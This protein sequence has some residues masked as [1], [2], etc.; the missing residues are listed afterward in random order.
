MTTTPTETTTCG[1]CAG[2]RI[3][4]TIEPNIRK[5][6][7]LTYQSAITPTVKRNYQCP[8][9]KGAGTVVKSKAA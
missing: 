5:Y 4:T 7:G 6:G 8:N 2:K 1:I 9:C 3:V